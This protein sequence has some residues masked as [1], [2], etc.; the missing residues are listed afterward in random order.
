[1]YEHASHLVL[2]LYVAYS[3]LFLPYAVPAYSSSHV[4]RSAEFE[5]TVDTLME[6]DRLVQLL[7]S[8]IFMYLRLQLLEPDRFVILPICL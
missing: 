6:I 1:M 5:M 7:E 8:P 4:F 2:K 3:P